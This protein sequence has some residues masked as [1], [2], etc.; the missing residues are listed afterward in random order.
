MMYQELLDKIVAES[1]RIFRS[2]LTGIYLHGS[3][4][5]QCFNP[6]KSDIDLIFVVEGGI[7][8]EQKLEFMNEVVKINKLAPNKG[9]ELSVVKRGHCKEIPYPIPFELHFSNMHLQWFLDNPTDYISKMKGTDKDLTAHFTIINH[10]GIVL[11]GEEIASVFGEVPKA[12]YID[13]IW[14]DIE[15]AKEEVLDNPIYIILNLCRVAAFLKDDLVTS[16]M[17]GGEWG[18]DNLELKYQKLIC[19]ALKCYASDNKMVVKKEEALAFAEY[20]LALIND[21]IVTNE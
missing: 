16:K 10:C 8:D 1:K 9:I 21:I 4:A 20:M 6:E 7:T 5:M 18:I 15:G 3:M 17:Q 12:D 14:T 13:S 19:D 2:E 11:Y